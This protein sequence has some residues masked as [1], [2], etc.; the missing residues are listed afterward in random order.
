MTFAEKLRELRD[1][2]GLSEAKL[3]EVSG[4]SFGSVHQY[5][6]SQGT[7]Q[8]KPSY[9]AVMKLCK[10]LKVS[11]EVFAECEDVLGDVDDEKPAA[12]PR[13]RAKKAE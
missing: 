8:R 3:A 5:G 6:L 13:A 2:A 4:L 12:K 11:C 1:A 10:A 7:G 9:A